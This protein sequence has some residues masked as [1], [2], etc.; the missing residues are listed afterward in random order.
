MREIP[1]NE[2]HHWWPEGVSKFWAGDTGHAH[3][4]ES[5]GELICSLPKSFGGIRNDN[6]I[7]FKSSPTVWDTSFEK[8]FAKADDAFPWLIA[9]LQTLSSPVT[10]KARPFAERLTPLT[11]EADRLD[12]LA[13]CLASL[14]ARSPS[15]R[16]RVSKASEYYR[17]RFGFPDPKPDKTLIAAGVRGAQEAFSK[18]LRLGGK[19][20]VLLGGDQE[21]VF[22]DGFLHNFSSLNHPMHPRCLIPLTP[23]IAVFYTRPRSYRA[24]PKLLVANLISDEVSFVNLTLQVYAQRYLF[25]RSIHPVI[26]EVFRQNVH[27]EFQYHKHPWIEQLE[28]AAAETYFGP[29][30]EFYPSD[31]RANAQAKEGGI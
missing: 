26:D 11:V 13:E 18:A 29:D 12:M 10:A 22:G 4:V 20:V 28:H 17:T 6:N 31:A 14:I 9:W 15:F 23:E 5:N 2:V 25:F 16:D 24:Y 3:R 19:F 7:T 27:L 30:N 1:K 21:F 8:S